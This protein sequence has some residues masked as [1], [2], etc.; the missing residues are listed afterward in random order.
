MPSLH[1]YIMSDDTSSSG[2]IQSVEIVLAILEIIRDEGAAGVSDVADA[3]AASKSTVHHYLTT[4]ESAGYVERAGQEYT[5]GLQFL[6]LGGRAREREQLFHLS[7]NDVDWLASE[8]EEKA[9]LIVERDWRGITLYQAE[10]ERVGETKTHV[11]STEPLHSTAAGKAFLAAVSDEETDTF[12]EET[13]LVAR[14]ANT[15]TDPDELYAELDRITERGVALDDEEHYEGVRCVAV[16]I[17]VDDDRVLG[18]LSVSAPTDRMPDDRFRSE[19][20]DTLQNVAGVVE[21][22]TTYSTWLDSP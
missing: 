21:I 4:L 18:T 5:L 19:L 2:H 11:G 14:T 17:V 16:P 3:L 20:P 15:I 12:V 8:T 10:G 22:N 6:T 13:D 7:R 1:I 9:R